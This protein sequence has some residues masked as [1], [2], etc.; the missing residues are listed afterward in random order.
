MSRP[1]SRQ[2]LAHGG[3]TR[4]LAPVRWT[5]ALPLAV[6]VLLVMLGVTSVLAL[7]LYRDAMGQMADVLTHDAQETARAQATGFASRSA[8]TRL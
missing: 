6:K 4:L 5:A 8:C 7:A 1:T 2:R 3:L